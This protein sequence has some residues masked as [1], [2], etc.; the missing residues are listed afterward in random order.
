MQNVLPSSVQDDLDALS[1]LLTLITRTSRDF[2]ASAPAFFGTAGVRYLIPTGAAA[3]PYVLGGLG[4]AN[5]ALKIEEVD[6]GDVTEDLVDEGYLDDD[7]INKLAVEAGGG[8]MF[9]AGAGFVDVGYRFMKLINTDEV[10][11][12]RAYVSIGVRF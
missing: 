8:V 12:S 6:L 9:N 2:E 3:R 11:I 10:N 7:H 5:I 4:F 1:A